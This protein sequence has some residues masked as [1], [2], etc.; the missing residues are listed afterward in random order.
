MGTY[1]IDFLVT[2]AWIVS[3]F[4]WSEQDSQTNLK[5]EFGSCS[6][7]AHIVCALV[8]SSLS[9]IWVWFGSVELSLGADFDLNNTF[10]ENYQTLCPT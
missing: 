2:S 1:H 8:W 7:D 10:T 9:L 3:G 6:S 5:Y 4:V